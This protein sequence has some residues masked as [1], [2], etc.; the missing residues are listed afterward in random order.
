[1]GKRVDSVEIRNSGHE[2]SLDLSTSTLLQTFVIRQ[3]RM[4]SCVRCRKERQR[5]EVRGF[6]AQH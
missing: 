6:S 2:L 4:A 5:E 1:M 3:E